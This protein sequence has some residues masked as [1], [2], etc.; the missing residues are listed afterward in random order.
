MV[1]RSGVAAISAGVAQATGDDDLLAQLIALRKRRNRSQAVVAARMG[2]S[3]SRVQ[4]LESGYRTP[5][6]ST[7]LRYVEAIGAQLVVVQTDG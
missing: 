4:H 6:L 3:P 5:N 1:Y 7:L 2:V